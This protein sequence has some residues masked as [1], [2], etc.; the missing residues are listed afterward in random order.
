M[1]D[2]NATPQA[3]DRP[4]R[5]RPWRRVGIALALLPVLLL[6]VAVAG[7]ALLHSE[8]GLRWL[9]PRVPGL[10]VDGVQGSLGSGRIAIARLRWDG[11]PGRLDVDA[12]ALDGLQWRLRPAPGQWVA[13]QADGLSA[14]RVAWVSAP[15][16]APAGPPTPIEALE[17]PLALQLPVTIGSLQVDTAPEVQDLSLQLALGADGGTEHRMTALSLRV[18]GGARLR[19]GRV[20]LGARAPMALDAALALASDDGAPLPW[21]AELQASGPLQRLAIGARL[22]GG[23]PGGT[24]MTVDLDAAVAPFARWPLAALSLSTAAL[25]LSALDARLPATR[26]DARAQVSGGGD[27]SPLQVDLQLANGTPGRWDQGQLPVRRVEARVQGDLATPGVVTIDALSVQLADGPTDGGR[28]QASG[29][30]DGHTLSLDNTLTGLRPLVLD[31]RALPLRLDGRIGVVARGL[32]SPDPA[33]AAATQAPA[34]ALDVALTGR[35]EGSDRPLQ[36]QARADLAAE[37]LVLERF[38]L[39][40]GAASARGSATVALA[41]ERWTVRSEGALSEFDPTPWL[42]GAPGAAW[43]Q[44]PHDLNARWSADLSLAAAALTQ[45]LA[46]WLPL[47]AGDARIDVLP[48][49]VA[50]LPLQAELA[51]SNVPGA[52]VAANV[53]LAGNRLRLNGRTDLREVGDGDTG[54]WELTLDAPALA[55]LAPLAALQP[56]AAA[57][58][59]EAGGAS[60]RATLEGRWPALRTEGE[61]TLSGLRANELR[62]GQARLHWRA[63]KGL[64]APLEARLS[65]DD[66]RWAGQGV[67]DLEAE[68]TGTL[69]SHRLTAQA[70]VPVLP[71]AALARSLALSLQRGTRLALQIDGGWTLRPPPPPPSPPERRRK[72]ERAGGDAAAVPAGGGRWTGQALGLEV[73][74]WNGEPLPAL[75]SDT[76]WVQASE[77]AATVDFAAGGGLERAQVDPGQIDLV[78]G[79]RLRWDEMRYEGE[80]DRLALRAAVENFRVAPLLARWQPDLGWAGDLDVGLQIEVRAGERFDADIVVERRSG[81]LSVLDGADRRLALGLTDLRLALNAHEGTWYFTQ[82][83]AGPTLGEVGGAIRVRTA[84]GQRWPEPEAPIDGAVQA[85]VANLGVWGTW[86]PPGWRLQGQLST[87]ARF[88]GSVGAPELSGTLTGSGLGARNLLLG[89]NVR[90]GEVAVRLDG[91]RATVENFV[92]RAGDGELRITG[93][94]TLGSAPSVQLAMAADRLQVLGRIDRRLVVSGDARLLVDPEQFALDGQLRVDSGLFDVSRSDAPTLDADVVV[95]RPGAEAPRMTATATAPAPARRIDVRVM[96]DL[97]DAL[98]LRGR[99]LET[100]LAGQLRVT[101]PAGQLAVNGI[102]NTVGG[103]YA[104]YGQK[105]VIERGRVTFTG[106]PDNPRLDVLALRQGLDAVDVGVEIVGGVAAPRV[107]LY[108]VPVM[109]DT[110]KLSWLVLGREPGAAGRADTALLQRAA[111]ALLSGEG[112]STSDQVIRSIGLDDLS[113]RQDD[114]SQETVISLGKQISDRWYVGYERSV[115]ATEGTWQVIYRAAR[116]FT[117]R[118]ES[119]VDQSLDAIWVWERP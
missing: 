76:P 111:V 94:A 80:G 59:P 74:S 79:I 90:D 35:L 48:S 83:L 6:A 37:R 57:W 69:A 64:E 108:S 12:L 100:R 62:V 118:A 45:P 24:P 88:G 102:V 58:A 42:P 16:D 19:D 68:L 11:A 67:Q 73:A 71:P 46:A 75:R 65:V 36:L 96:V 5:A 119:G 17:L 23:P 32:P 116:R 110:D 39:V 78:G 14:D 26:L 34:A 106:E 91:E 41:G 10:T 47:L 86:V 50:G 66:T 22:T 112:E 18:V 82:A 13:L 113:L 95:R 31:A 25:D 15:G 72:S 105:M 61:F 84:P 56:D 92:L 4:R 40:S 44:G 85:R 99:G 21:Q 87:E 115:S 1:A 98:R 54:Q 60:A 103:T 117:L 109:S 97:G 107:R 9:L 30:W 52:R 20:Q 51:I 3:P 63:D 81:D 43:R 77:I 8:A 89:V 101:A 114:V 28:W 55:A 2:D 104:A 29:R 53:E 70:A 38:E 93:G 49:R 7:W 33:A 27:G